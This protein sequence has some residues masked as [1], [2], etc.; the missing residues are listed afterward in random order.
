MDSKKTFHILRIVFA[1]LLRRKTMASTTT[2]TMKMKTNAPRCVMVYM[3]ATTYAKLYK[4]NDALRLVRFGSLAI[5][6][7]AL[8]WQMGHRANHTAYVYIYANH[9]NITVCIHICVVCIRHADENVRA[10]QEE[11]NSLNGD[12]V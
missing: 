9:S 8:R 6:P 2:T 5:A 11:Q 12:V 10:A 1:H 7:N 3:C 4:R